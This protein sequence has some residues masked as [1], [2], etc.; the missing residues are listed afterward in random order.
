M[1]K[2][3]ESIDRKTSIEPMELY[4]FRP[5]FH[6]KSSVTLQDMLGSTLDFA[7]KVNEYLDIIDV[8]EEEQRLE[9]EAAHNSGIPNRRR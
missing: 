9:M 4:V 2:L 1:Q 8:L 7:L 3:Y 5:V 6:E